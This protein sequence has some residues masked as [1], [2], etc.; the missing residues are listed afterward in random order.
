MNSNM[1]WHNR[2]ASLV[3]SQA[4]VARIQSNQLLA[5][6][7]GPAPS[8]FLGRA[9]HLQARLASVC[10]ACINFITYMH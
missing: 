10:Q 6:S 4:E 7:P 1:N 5:Q 9:K 2:N 8:G 3:L